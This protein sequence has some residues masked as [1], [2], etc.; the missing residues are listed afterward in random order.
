MCRAVHPHVRGEDRRFRSSRCHLSGSP[1]RAWG[2]PRHVRASVASDRFTP[3]CVG[4][5]GCIAIWMGDTAV[6]PPRGVG[7]TPR[8]CIAP[9]GC[10]VHPHVRGEDACPVRRMSFMPGSPPRAWGKTMCVSGFWLYLTVHPHVRG[11]RLLRPV[12]L[13][14]KSPVHP[15]V[16]GEDYGAAFCVCGVGG[17]PPRAWGRHFRHWKRLDQCRFTPTCVGKTLAGFTGHRRPPV[18]PHVRGEDS[19]TR[20]PSF[21]QR[22]SPPRAWGRR[23]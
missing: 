5:T 4:K 3:T 8:C 15:H 9:P 17:S 10:T 22:G 6:S 12:V 14:F 11:G 16:R 1:P 13:P 21:T 18:H 23:Y 2:R 7:K 19:E 20:W